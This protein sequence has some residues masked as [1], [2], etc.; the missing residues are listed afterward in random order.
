[1]DSK[2]LNKLLEA[3]YGEILVRFDVFQNPI[4]CCKSGWY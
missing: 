1:M 3:T 4:L 2:W